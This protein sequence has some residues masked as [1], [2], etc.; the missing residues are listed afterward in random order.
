MAE[1]R[2]RNLKFCWFSYLILSVYL[3]SIHFDEHPGAILNNCHL[4]GFCLSLSLLHLPTPYKNMRL[5]K[6]LEV[7]VEFFLLTQ[8]FIFV[9][10]RMASQLRKLWQHASLRVSDIFGRCWEFG[11]ALKFLHCN[12]LGSK[13]SSDHCYQ[14]RGEVSIVF[15]NLWPVSTYNKGGGYSYLFVYVWAGVC[16][17]SFFF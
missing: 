5:W 16:Q 14:K 17:N 2:Q 3:G 13:T 15:R 8:E 9:K 1:G 12:C 11:N 4:Y 10:D 7:S 6:I